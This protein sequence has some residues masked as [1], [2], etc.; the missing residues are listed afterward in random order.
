MSPWLAPLLGYLGDG[1]LPADDLPLARASLGSLNA[2]Q[3]LLD[4]V[5]VVDAVL[6]CETLAA[7]AVVLRIR[8][9]G[10]SGIDDAA[11]S[12]VDLQTAAAKAVAAA[13]AVKDLILVALCVC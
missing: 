4:A 7:D 1:L 13:L 11:L 6:E 10:H 2:P 9:V 5:G 3:G 12:N 8:V